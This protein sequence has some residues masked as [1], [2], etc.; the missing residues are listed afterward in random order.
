MGERGTRGLECAKL[1]RSIGASS[2]RGYGTSGARHAAAWTRTQLRTAVP[3]TIRLLVSAAKRRHNQ[4]MPYL[5]LE[6]VRSRRDQRVSGWFASVQ[7]LGE[8]KSQA[9]VDVSPS[10]SHARRKEE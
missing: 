10:R 6:A 7:S 4:I 5:L 2:P 3:P 9:S 8:C 1:G